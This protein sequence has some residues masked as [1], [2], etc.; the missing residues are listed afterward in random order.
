M[1]KIILRHLRTKVAVERVAKPT[2][3]R[4]RLNFE[5][6]EERDCPSTIHVT[7]L[8][9]SPLASVH[10]GTTLRDAIAASETRA[11][12]HGAI[13]GTGTDTI[14]FDVNGQITLSNNDLDVAFG[15]TALVIK[16]FSPSNPTNITIQGGVSGITLDGDNPVI[17]HRLFGI[18]AG[19]TLTLD[20]VTLQ[21]GR[22]TGGNGS[23]GSTGGGGAAGLG[24]AI[25]NFQGIL[26]INN[27]TLIG[28]TVQGGN[29]GGA[30]TGDS[31]GGGGGGVGGD[32]GGGFSGGGG[33]GGGIGG[34]GTRNSAGG[35][36]GVGEIGAAGPNTAGSRGGG[37][38]GG[39]GGNGGA[40][41]SLSTGG[42]GG[43]GGGFSGGITV[44]G[45]GGFGG[46]G[47]GGSGSGGF[48]GGGGGGIGG[49]GGFGGFAG[50]GGGGGAS[51]LG[52]GGGGGGGGMGG[53]VFNNGGTTTI[54][55]STFTANMA[56]G[57]TGG[58]TAA[59]GKGF[60][61]AIFSRNGTLTLL[62]DTISGNTANDGG[63]GVYVLGDGAA[64]TAKVNNS[65]IG[66]ANN[67]VTDFVQNTNGGGTVSSSG[68]NNLVRNQ[69]TF[70]GTSN[71]AD[72]MLNALASNG[73]PTQ[74]MT[75]QA[76]SPA[77]D[78][79]N[80]AIAPSSDQR[81]IARPQ[82]SQTD[83]GALELK[84]QIAIAGGTSQ[85]TTVNTNFANLLTVQVTSPDLGGA[86]L[87]GQVVTFT[88]TP[89]GGAGATF[90]SSS[91]PST[92]ASGIASVSLQANGTA[93]TYILPA[94]VSGSF[95]NFT[96][97]NNAALSITPNSLPA[98]TTGVAYI[99]TITVNGGTTPYTT[100]NFSAFNGGGTGL[101]AANITTNAGAGTF[102]IN[103]TPTGVGTVSFTV[104]VQDTAGAMLSKMYSITVTLATA[105]SLTFTQQPTTVRASQPQT[106]AV[107]ALNA[108]GN[109]AMQFNGP[110]TLQ[111]V[112]PSGNVTTLA[113]VNA[114]NG[115]ATFTNVV[116]TTPAK[117]Y[118]LQ[119]IA[120]GLTAATSNPFDLTS[121][122]VFG[123][124]RPHR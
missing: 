50:F 117:G 12:V 84:R 37:G 63:R 16:D 109:P 28:N 32:G 111:L 98:G 27:S 65:I 121:L 112:D 107:T 62:N 72:P 74:T 23:S 10:A 9:D 35:I 53:A 36:G 99:Q 89:F 69:A 17:L 45:A 20:H 59:S 122:V 42:F 113:T 26:N 90:T 83:I 93:G 101:T 71:S 38:G 52:G 13:A 79:G 43:G 108:Q 3:R 61:G 102:V 78:G 47:G 34:A 5:Q 2:R 116:V 67:A 25:V 96:E 66:Q 58:G 51:T 30:G 33:G 46:G 82:G 49:I 70:Q 21:N 123:R 4:V 48:G 88:V 22:A 8:I 92:N 86:A 19:D 44:G 40:A 18:K 87:A 73:G 76:T 106:V 118:K 11:P 77:L 39:F 105:Q 54:T 91:T 95:V 14:V 114:V 104:N 57:G 115:V 41:T 1:W 60:G 103:G 120:A 100:F 94:A 85:A 31:A 6:L 15:P 110:V 55:N 68:A 7:T 119:A 24:G 56:A 81:G 80:S 75:F 64:A 97:S 124:R 29:G